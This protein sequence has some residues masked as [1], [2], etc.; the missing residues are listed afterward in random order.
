MATL[1]QTDTTEIL[2]FGEFAEPHGERLTDLVDLRHRL[3]EAMGELRPK[4]RSAIRLTFFNEMTQAEAGKLLGLS[5]TRVS[6][7][8][9]RALRRLRHPERCRILELHLF[10]AI[11]W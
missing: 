2:E 7:I 3:E 4:E 8:C 10:D 1:H 5:A 11:G 9:L 6:Q